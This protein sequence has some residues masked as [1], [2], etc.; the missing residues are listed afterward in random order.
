MLFFSLQKDQVF[1]KGPEFKNA[2]KP[3]EPANETTVLINILYLRVFKRKELYLLLS[4]S[5]LYI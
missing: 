4:R 5:Q 1:S 2:L 3:A